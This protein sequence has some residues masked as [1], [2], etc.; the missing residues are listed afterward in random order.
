MLYIL[1]IYKLTLH[2][3]SDAKFETYSLVCD[4]ISDVCKSEVT[5]IELPTFLSFVRS[6]M[7][8]KLR[9]TSS[10]TKYLTSIINRLCTS[11]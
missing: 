3:I 11:Y 1:F 6:R 2:L 10:I 8:T 7:C 9:L 5:R 4:I